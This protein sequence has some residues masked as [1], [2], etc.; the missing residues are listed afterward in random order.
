MRREGEI[1]QKSPSADGFTRQW[2]QI[3]QWGKKVRLRQIHSMNKQ[4]ARGV[5]G[6][7]LTSQFL[8]SAGSS[9]GEQRKGNLSHSGKDAKTCTE[10]THIIEPQERG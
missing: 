9:E 2:N 8:L 1:P 4:K 3:L 7:I 10:F 5:S 6:R